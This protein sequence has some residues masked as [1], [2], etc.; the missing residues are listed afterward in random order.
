MPAYNAAMQIE[1]LAFRRGA[2]MPLVAA[3]ACAS[4]SPPAAAPGPGATAGD[5]AES[6]L[7]HLIAGDRAALH[8]AFSGEPAVDDPLG[9]RVRGAQ[10]FDS[11]VAERQAWLQARSAR[12]SP[13]RTTRG[14]DRTVAEAVLDLRE[15]DKAIE[16]P[17]AVVADRAPDGRARAIRVYHSLWPLEGKHRVRPPL[18]PLDPAVHPTG[19]VAAYQRALAAGD[20]EAI[21]ASFE[22]DGYFREPSGGVYVHRGPTEL[23]AFMAQILGAGGIGI[24]HATLTDDG[25]VA[26]IEF[27]AVRFGRR[28]LTPQA[29]LAVYERGRAAASPPPASTTTST[30]RCSPLPSRPTAARVADHLD[31]VPLAVLDEGRVVVGPVVRTRS[32]LAVVPAARRQ[33]RPVKRVDLFAVVDAERIVSVPRGAWIPH[34]PED[35]LVARA[36][37]ER[38]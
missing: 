30:S 25:V 10:A 14:A 19:A 20:L 15:G 7:G 24:E 9:G 12:L 4:A 22:P 17:I 5:P 27:N 11:F 1:Q 34:Q 35:V 36:E 6:Y 13:R 3:C 21:L 16:L 31:V 32:G 29:G 8:A 38:R 23:R 33:R 28:P 18:L 2:L 37:T 26:A